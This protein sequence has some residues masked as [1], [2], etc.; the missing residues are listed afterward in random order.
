MERI[1]LE[2]GGAPL[3]GSLTVPGDKSVS[4]RAVMFGSIAEGRTTVSGFLSGE[5]CLR[6]IDCFRSLG[7]SIE[8]EGTDLVIDSPGIDGWKEPSDILYTGNS[9]T[10][11]RLILGVL[12]GS[13]VHSVVTGDSSIAKRPMKR[14]T[15]PLDRMG[16]D[17]R[18]REGAQYTPLSVQGGQLRAIDYDMPVASAQ[19]KSA[20]LFAALRADG[21]SVIREKEVSRDHTERM[22][23]NFGIQVSSEEG[24]IRLQGGQKP[25]AVHVDVPGDISSAAFF[26]AAG[27]LVPD[28]EVSLE[29]V[30]LNPT[31]SGMLDV[32]EAMGAEIR[33]TESGSSDSEPRGTLTVRH[34]SLRGTEISG[35]LIPR[36]IDEI[37]VIALL[38]TQ[39]E[40][41]TV[42]KDAEELRVKETDRIAAVA[43]ELG[44]LGADIEPTADGMIIRGPVRLGGGT[45][46]SRGDH[47]IGMMA[48]IASLIADGPVELEDPDCIAV[49]YPAFFEH[50]DSLQK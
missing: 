21:E 39:A 17:I 38:A 25:V 4:H 11:T 45:L 31:R 2:Y 27:A 28:S 40:G 43:E 35:P 32:L 36:L 29:N 9:G 50:L 44:K 34:S 12:A 41:T 18:G 19:V 30:G 16:A 3:R 47:R 42:I 22:M 15:D 26:L 20:I 10:T 33:V 49:S 5:D 8:R 46:D 14:V 13:R 1:K 23:H 48:A 37:P 7:V 6:T 24:T